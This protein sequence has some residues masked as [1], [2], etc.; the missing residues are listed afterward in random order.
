MQIARASP[1]AVCVL[2]TIARTGL[3]ILSRACVLDM[4]MFIVFLQC[5]Y[6]PLIIV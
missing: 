2:T 4:H 1:W 3:D 5:V 6:S